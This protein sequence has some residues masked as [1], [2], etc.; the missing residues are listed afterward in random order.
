MHQLNKLK[1]SHKSVFHNDEVDIF[2]KNFLGN[3]DKKMWFCLSKGK[4]RVK[5]RVY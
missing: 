5:L 3:I 2:A 4:K 1:L